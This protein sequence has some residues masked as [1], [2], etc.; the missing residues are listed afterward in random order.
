MER[1]NGA[2]KAWRRAT[3]SGIGSVKTEDL[4]IFWRLDAE[5]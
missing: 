3:R 2:K 1:M 5:N 4:S